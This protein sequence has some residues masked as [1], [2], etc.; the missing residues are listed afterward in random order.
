MM[1]MAMVM[2]VMMMMMVMVMMMEFSYSRQ[3]PLRNKYATART[4]V[5]SHLLGYDYVRIRLGLR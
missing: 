1:V 3:Q 2:M 5:V 4:I